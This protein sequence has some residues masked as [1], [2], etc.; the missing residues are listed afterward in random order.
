LTPGARGLTIFRT[1]TMPNIKWAF[2]S[3]VLLTNARAMGE[4]GAVSVVSGHIRGLTNTMPLQVEILYNEYSVAAVFSLASLLACLA[5]VTLGLKTILSDAERTAV[6]GRDV[7]DAAD[8]ASAGPDRSFA[9]TFGA[10]RAIS[11]RGLS[12][13]FGAEPI[14][15]HVDLDIAPGELLALLGPSGSGKTTLLR[16]LAGLETASEGAIAFDGEDA[17]LHSVQERRV[18]F[19]F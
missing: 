7:T 11:I 13:A 6:I 8:R 19:V 9:R 12:K 16:L 18:G 10:P 1:V 17:A 5:L 3:G 2:L 15:D 4:F 14:L